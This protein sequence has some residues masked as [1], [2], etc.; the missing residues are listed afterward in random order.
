MQNIDIYFK[1]NKNQK[2]NASG[3][4]ILTSNGVKDVT[5]YYSTFEM[6]KVNKNMLKWVMKMH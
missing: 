6:I 5:A 1:Q 2:F 3:I 4:E